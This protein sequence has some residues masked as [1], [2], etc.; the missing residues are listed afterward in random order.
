MTNYQHNTEELKVHAILFKGTPKNLETVIS[1]LRGSLCQMDLVTF[2][3]KKKELAIP[4]DENKMD[5]AKEK[6]HYI[7]VTEEGN[8]DICEKL[9][10][11]KNFKKVSAEKKEVVQDDTEPQSEMPQILKDVKSKNMARKI[12]KGQMYINRKGG[13]LNVHNSEGVITAKNLVLK[14]EDLYATDWIEVE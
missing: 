12:W 4:G 2:D 14:D 3:K 1:L 6:E 5:I 11:E 13:S 7:Y 10:F 9:E 8:Y